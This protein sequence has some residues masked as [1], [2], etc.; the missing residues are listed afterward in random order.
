MTGYGES[1]CTLSSCHLFILSPFDPQQAMK[2]FSI[3]SALLILSAV[4]PASRGQALP[5]PPKQGPAPLL[6]VRLLGPAGTR[7]TFYQGSPA[8]REVILPVTVGLRPGY[9]YRLKVS[10]LPGRPGLELFPTL[11]V[12]GTLL[13]PAS[14]RAS[15]YPAP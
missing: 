7:V 15:D 10:N 11:E 9:A 12:R 5:T 1:L 2:H 14:L 3:F 6:F 4:Q 13:L 8:G